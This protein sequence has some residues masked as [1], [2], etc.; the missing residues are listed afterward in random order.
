MSHADLVFRNATIVDG[1]GA[2]SFVGDVAIEGDRI[3]SVGSFTGTADEEIDASG[4]ALAPGFIDIHTHFDPQ[5]CWDRLATPSLEHGV[6]TVVI[7]NCSLSLAPVRPGKSKKLV[8][9]FEVIEDIKQRTFDTAV[10]FSW[11][12]FAEYLDHVRPGLGINVAAMVGHSALRYYVMGDE[13]QKRAASEA[14]VAKMCRLLEQAMEAGA[15][16]LSGSY[17]DSDNTMTPVPCRFAELSETIALCKAMRK[18]GRGVYQVV[19]YFIELPEQLKNIAEL[20]E[21]SRAADVMCSLQPILS[22]PQS[23][24]ARESIEALEAERDKGGRVYGQVM[25]RNFD[26]NMRLSETTMLLFPLPRW[27]AIMDE[28]MP[29]RIASFADPAR[30]QDLIDEMSNAG[31]MAAAIPFLKVRSAVS[32]SNQQY[33]GRV[34]LEIAGAEKKSVAEVILDIALADDLETEFQLAG[35][36]N[37]DKKA[38]GRLMDHPLCHVG[39]SDAGAHITQ[40]CGSGDTTHLLEHYVR[41]TGQMTLERA[42]HRM[43]DELAQAWGIRDRGRIEEG[44]A[45]DLV[46]FDPATVSVGA[47]EFA[48]DFPGE[49]SRYLRHGSGYHAVLVNGQIVMRDGKYTDARSGLIV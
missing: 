30:R 38:V 41:E 3:A 37:A 32:E 20:G 27:K 46:L 26:L 39:A 44:L 2:P 9:M 16:G 22:G 42:V 25:P 23:P 35:V 12:S 6:T 7:G 28:A 47:D 31:S 8:Q 36:L 4:L 17:V 1:S 14:E 40:F 19:P 13:S 48:N 49:A 33:V 5:L 21:I 18:S 45:A 29:G 34:L 15:L 43:T 24:E 10:P 11:E